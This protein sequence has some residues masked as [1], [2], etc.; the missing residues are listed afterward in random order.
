MAK[1]IGSRVG[2]GGSFHVLGFIEQMLFESGSVS[3]E[4]SRGKSMPGK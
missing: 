3:H 4:D 2:E 1:K